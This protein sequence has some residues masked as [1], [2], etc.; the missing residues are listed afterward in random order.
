M[1]F[2]LPGIDVKTLADTGVWMT[3]KQFNSDEPLLDKKGKPVRL[4]LLGPDS[5]VYRDF[6]RA[7]I[8]KR[9]ASDAAG[10]TQAV[11][12]FDD[13]DRETNILFAK[14]TVAWEGINS[15][16]GKPVPYDHETALKL[17]ADFPV[18]REQLD[19]F[20]NERANF[21]KASSKS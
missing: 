8:R 19:R 11:P 21:L 10:T 20:V 5:D 13:I 7:Q 14:L 1:E 9:L 15:P 4:K 3:V 2:D 18:L 16:D 12:D 17:F 6:A